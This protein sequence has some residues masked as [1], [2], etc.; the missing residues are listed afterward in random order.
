MAE[1][2]ELFLYSNKLSQESMVHFVRELCA[3]SR[4]EISKDNTVTV[5]AGE[6][7]LDI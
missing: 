7:D 5:V 1:L 3:V 6:G 2:D 4:E